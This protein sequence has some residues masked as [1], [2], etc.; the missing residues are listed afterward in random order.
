MLF[1]DYDF[2]E[3]ILTLDSSV[4][5]IRRK[6]DILIDEKLKKELVLK[7]EN[8]SKHLKELSNQMWE[9]VFKEIEN[10]A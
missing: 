6:I 5:D 7:L 3:G 8:K 2:E 4:D 9:K 10:K 1:K